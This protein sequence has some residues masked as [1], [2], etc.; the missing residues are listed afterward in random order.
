MVLAATRPGPIAGLLWH[1][2]TLHGRTGNF[3]GESSMRKLAAGL[4]PLLLA[5]SLAGIPFS[6]AGAEDDGASG[7][8]DQ[9]QVENLDDGNVGDFDDGAMNDLDDGAVD[10]VDDGAVDDVDDGAVDDVDDG[11][12]DDVD[13]GDVDDGSIDG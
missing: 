5:G 11:T 8:V 1:N 4:L 6:V 9:D 3:R 7:D 10:D 12:V 2:V 13:D